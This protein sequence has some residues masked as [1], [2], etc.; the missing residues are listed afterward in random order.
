MRPRNALLAASA[1]LLVAGC[2]IQTQPD[3]DAVCQAY[4]AA[5][6]H[7]EVIA[8]GPVTD[9][10]GVRPGRVSAHEGFLMRVRATC[11]VIVRVESNVDFTGT[12]PLARGQRVQVKG[13]YEYYRRGGVIHW[14]HRDPRLRHQGG[15]VEVAGRTYD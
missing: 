9:V 13:E 10:L 14:T 3:N 1:V 7:V 15:Y 5:R 4:R 6:S 11:D 2:A 8:S 12:F